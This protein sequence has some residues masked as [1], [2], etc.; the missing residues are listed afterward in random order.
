M[1]LPINMPPVTGSSTHRLTGALDYRSGVYG[2]VI[3]ISTGRRVITG[4]PLWCGV[5]R[6]EQPFSGL[7][8]M[9]PRGHP[10]QVYVDFAMGFGRSLAPE[11]ERESIGIARIWAN[12]VLIYDARDPLVA[13]KW[14]NFK[15]TV[16]RG[17]STQGVD[18]TMYA[19]KGD[20]TPAYHNEIYVVFNSFP[21]SAWAIPAVRAELVDELTITAVHEPFDMLDTVLLPESESCFVNWGT[22]QFWT[23]SQPLEDNDATLHQLDLNSLEEVSRLPITGSYESLSLDTCVYDP[24]NAIFVSVDSVSNR[25]PIHFIS[26]DTGATLATFGTFAPGS[27][28]PDGIGYADR[29]CIIKCTEGG[30]E[31]RAYLALSWISDEL[32]ILQFN[33]PV[34]AFSGVTFREILPFTDI[35]CILFFPTWDTPQNVKN[36]YRSG[37]QD[38][39]VFIGTSSG[40][41]YRQGLGAYG[42]QIR[43][44]SDL[45][46]IYDFGAGAAVKL[47]ILD[48]KDGFLTVIYEEG[49][50]RAAKFRVMLPGNL[51][52][53]V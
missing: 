34:G 21:T 46:L 28:G 30:I 23:I 35:E 44:N 2:Q 22:G 52:P 50:S 47:L 5:F 29:G 37:T 31:Y 9:T 26:V 40:K 39:Y 12:G 17:S 27:S 33:G 14:P 13:K 19:D 38:A 7:T 20:T 10:G 6:R 51:L 48:Q 24:E 49:G 25:S 53:S 45:T 43:Y 41:L 4:V 8:G 1:A 16:Y 15:F 18:A 11:E 3:P 36:P 42:G 32:T